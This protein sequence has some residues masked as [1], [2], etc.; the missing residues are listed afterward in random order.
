MKKVFNVSRYRELLKKVNIL[1]QQN[2]FLFDEPEFME[3]LSYGASVERQIHFSRKSEYCSLIKKYVYKTLPPHIFRGEFLEMV[4][5]DTEKAEKIL[6]DF[7]QLS[8]F[9]ISVNLL[10]EDKDEFSSS[11]ERISDKCLQAFEFGPEDDGYGI[12]E[13]EFRNSI[14]ESYFKLENYL[15]EK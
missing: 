4:E 5:Q 15:N 11:F 2:K 3:F 10:D 9:S 7:N 12:P 6:Q 1:E 13:D 8:N 14:E